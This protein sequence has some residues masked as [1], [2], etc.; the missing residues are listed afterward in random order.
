MAHSKSTKIVLK[1]LKFILPVSIGLLLCYLIYAQLSAGEKQDLFDALLNARY[2]WFALSFILGLLSHVSRAYRWKYLLQPLGK[3]P[4]FRHSFYAVMIGYLFNMV[5]PRAGEASRALA[6]SRSENIPFERTFGTIFAERIIDMLVLAAIT[7]TT[8]Y[9]QIEVLGEQFDALQSGLLDKFSWVFLTAVGLGILAVILLLRFGRRS[10]FAPVRKIYLLGLGFYAGLKTIVKMRNKWYFLFHTALI[11]LLYVGM[12]WVCF[13]ALEQTSSVPVSGVFAGFV[14]GSFAVVLFP[15]G[16]GAYPVAI[17]K[18]L[19]LYGIAGA[20]GFAL[21][22][23]M[24]C[25]QTVVIVTFGFISLYLT[26]KFNAKKMVGN[27]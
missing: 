12:Y 18:A 20:Y 15:G 22:W 5:L 19:I 2:E 1:T 17:Q 26:P 13:F 10:R 7:L 11:W 4:T 6:L 9:L 16:I 8:F 27:A 14:L 21:G 23:I 3:I 24:W 25:A